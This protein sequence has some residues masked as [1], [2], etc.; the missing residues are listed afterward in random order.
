M[1]PPSTLVL[2]VGGSPYQ[3]RADRLGLHRRLHRPLGGGQPGT[4][5]ASCAAGGGAGADGVGGTA[6]GDAPLLPALGTLTG[7]GWTP[8]PG[9]RG[10]AGTRAQ[11]GGGGGA[12]TGAGGGGGSGGCGGTGGDGGGGGGGASAALLIVASKVSISATRL[13]GGPAGAGGSG[14]AGQLGQPPGGGGGG[15]TVSAGFDGC[16]GGQGGSGGQGGA[17]GGGAGGTAT[18]VLTKAGATFVKDDASTLTPGA[19]GAKGKGAG[20]SNDGLAA[21]VAP[22]LEIP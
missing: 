20:A 16:A 4:L 12:R 11:G 9:G 17:G 13:T 22:T 19:P 3:L 7:A 14:A 15:A 10:A 5:G 2:A 6:G 1:T 18:A 8:S 21:P